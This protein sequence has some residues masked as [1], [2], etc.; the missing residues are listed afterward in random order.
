MNLSN[1]SQLNHYYQHYSRRSG[2]CS[3]IVHIELWAKDEFRIVK[4]VCKS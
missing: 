1:S 3:K 2:Y 4:P